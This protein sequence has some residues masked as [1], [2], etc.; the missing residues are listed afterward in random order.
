MSLHQSQ[1]ISNLSFI[2]SDEDYE[3]EEKISSNPY[4]LKTWLS[5]IQ[6][7]Q[8][9]QTHFSNYNNMINIIFER[10]LSFLPGSYKLWNMYLNVRVVQCENLHPVTAPDS[11]RYSLPNKSSTYSPSL[12]SGTFTESP[13]IEKSEDLQIIEAVNTVFE[14]SLITMHRMPMIWLKYLKFLVRHQPTITS[15]RLVLNR[16]LQ[17][18]P[19]TQ[20]HLIWKFIVHDWILKDQCKVPKTTSHRLLKRYLRLDPTFIGTFIDYLTNT[21]SYS[22]VCDILIFILN[23]NSESDAWAT[24]SKDDSQVKP[25]DVICEQNESLALQKAAIHFLTEHSPLEVWNLLC[26]TLSEHALQVM[27]PH[28]KIESALIS[29]I[30]RYPSEVGKLWTTLA[31][32]YVQYGKFDIA[33]NCYEQGM[34]SVSTVKDWNLIFDTYSKLYDELIRINI[35]SIEKSTNTISEVDLEILIAKYENLMDR[36][37]FLLNS[38]KLKQNPNNIHEWHNRIKL[39]KNSGTLN[40]D[41]IEQIIDA[42][43][44]AIN[45]I[46][47]ESI[48]HGKMYSIWNSYARF[49]E[50]ET[51]S[52]EKARDVYGRCIFNTDS[53]AYILSTQDLEKV[54]C[55]YAEMEIRNKNYQNALS[56]LYRI[57]HSGPE[58]STTFSLST[59]SYRKSVMIWSFLLDLELCL[60]KNVKRVKKL[61]NEMLDLKIVTPNIVINVANYLIEHQYFE[62]GFKIF[63]RAIS[64]FYY[65]QVYPIWI[66]YLMQFIHRYQHLKLER[67]RDMFEQ[68]ISTM[69][70]YSKEAVIHQFSSGK[71][72]YVKNSHSRDFFLLYSSFEEKYGISSRAIKVYEKAVSSV[73][74]NS[75]EQFQLYQV[76]IDRI[77][78]LFGIAKTRNVIDTALNQSVESND[79][80]DLSCAFIRDLSLKYIY[81]ELKLG[82]VDRCR[83]IFAFCS[84]LCSPDVTEH[85]NKFW[86]RW[87]KFEKQYGNVETFKEMLR[88]RRFVKQQNGA[89]GSS[90]VKK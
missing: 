28:S 20:H 79:G 45:T 22:E 44:S 63:E 84:S 36:R 43:E 11:I 68:A 38:V 29:G 13:P 32:Y 4:L 90:F 72:Y 8:S 40:E 6:Y 69:P 35:S 57:V 26:T 39:V 53:K 2:C 88:I 25:N 24:R 85:F 1:V 60:N 81:L 71:K 30:N 54:V 80:T 34:N 41:L 23:V 7:K 77:G 58:S 18:L 86:E 89:S 21:E 50:I 74:P 52:V 17:A 5:Y 62:E 12:E 14:K 87:S 47:P 83:S 59:I 33:M 10:A 3:F 65:P 56:L 51:K 76:Y 31:Q 27:L 61:Y 55:D 9:Y 15:V 70:F 67:T 82:E 46:N 78:D 37:P 16:S 66:Q 75:L 19:I 49:F 48:T 42:Y 73:T 64:M